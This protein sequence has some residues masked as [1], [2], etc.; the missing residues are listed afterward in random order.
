MPDEN[1]TNMSDAKL[2]KLAR[3]EM[4]RKRIGETRDIRNRVQIE[5]EIEDSEYQL[6]KQEEQKE[7]KL[8]QYISQKSNRHMNETN[9]E[10]NYENSLE[11]TNELL[12]A[13]NFKLGVIVFVFVFL[14]LV[15]AIFIK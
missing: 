10:N 14:P 9:E 7:I 15:W 13:I 3:E 5:T 11:R 2:A 8:N 4:S 6:R 12:Y 1:L